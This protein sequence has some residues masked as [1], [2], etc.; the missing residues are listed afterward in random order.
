MGVGTRGRAGQG[1]WS[2][3]AQSRAGP[4][5]T[6]HAHRRLELRGGDLAEAQAVEVLQEVLDA[7]PSLVDVLLQPP[8][9]GVE[10]HLLAARHGCCLA[11]ISQ[12]RAWGVMLA[13][14]QLLRR[15]HAPHGSAELGRMER[16]A[17]PC[18][19]RGRCIHHRR[20]PLRA[21]AFAAVS[22]CPCAR[23]GFRPRSVSP[24]IAS[25]SPA[26]DPTRARDQWRAR[27][28]LPRR[29]VDGR[30]ANRAPPGPL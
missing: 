9:G 30:L 13:G 27:C 14:I 1:R 10:G 8:H 24:A 28:L 6:C 22:A 2:R 17:T 5:R 3:P 15:S 12:K 19:F 18:P 21:R 11:G 7:Q 25:S 4:L 29:R 16:R 23:E 20:G 26:P